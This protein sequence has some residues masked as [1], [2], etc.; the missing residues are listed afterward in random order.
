MGTPRLPIPVSPYP[1]HPIHSG[2]NCCTISKTY[3]DGSARAERN[4]STPLA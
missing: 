4:I 1:A 2:A 3:R